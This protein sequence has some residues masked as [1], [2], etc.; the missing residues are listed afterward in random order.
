MCGAKVGDLEPCPARVKRTDNQISESVRAGKERAWD[1][2]SKLL[3]SEDPDLRQLAVQYIASWVTNRSQKAYNDLIEKL[4]PKKL[5]EELSSKLLDEEFELEAFTGCSGCHEGIYRSQVHLGGYDFEVH[6][7]ECSGCEDCNGW[8]PLKTK[9]PP[10]HEQVWI[11]LDDWVF[12][13]SYSEARTDTLGNERPAQ[14]CTDCWY[15]DALPEH[16]W[17]PYIIPDPPK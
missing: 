5:L 11:F 8:K 10:C 7:E 2:A 3:T 9:V 12:P 4:V 16:K 17:K 15:G 13:A 6:E 14:W 1:T